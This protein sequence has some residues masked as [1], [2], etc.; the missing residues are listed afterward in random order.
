MSKNNPGGLK[1]RRLEPKIVE[2]YENLENPDRCFIKLYECYLM[3]C[4]I[5]SER[6]N[7]SFYLTPLKKPKTNVWYSSVPVGHNTLVKTVGR[8]CAAAGNEGFKTNHSL[9]VTTEPGYFKQVWK[10]S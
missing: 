4:P 6:K 10:N 3:H 8:I 1:H 9:R 2:H 7:L 5:E